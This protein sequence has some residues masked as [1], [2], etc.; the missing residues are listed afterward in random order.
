MAVAAPQTECLGLRVLIGAAGDLSIYSS[1]HAHV[2]NRANRTEAP[3]SQAQTV[4]GRHR[5]AFYSTKTLSYLEPSAQV[6]DVTCV[7][8]NGSHRQILVGQR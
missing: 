1:V 6:L 4:S 5:D 7:P 8:T 2:R 3:S